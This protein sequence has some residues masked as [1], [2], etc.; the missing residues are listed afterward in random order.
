MDRPDEI[1]SCYVCVNI[2][3]AEGGSR[4]IKE[5]IAERLAA[6]GSPAEVKEYICFGACTMGP[7][8]VLYPEGTWYT[9]V[10]AGDVDDVVAHVLGGP[11]VKRLTERI[12]PGLHDL[13]LEILDAG[14]D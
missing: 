1:R 9:N 5:A 3:C 7:N 6:E 2:F 13:I 12:D 4:E 8:L 11:R 14:I 10:E